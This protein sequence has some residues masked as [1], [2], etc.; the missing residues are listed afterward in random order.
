MSARERERLKLFERVKREELSLRD[1]AAICS[2]SYRQT[3]RLY[4]RYR[5]EG[6]RNM[7]H[8]SRGRQTELC[9]R[10]LK[11]WFSPLSGNILTL[12]QPWRLRSRRSKVTGWTTRRCAVGC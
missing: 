12:A 11:R 7:V 4:K 2:F 8:R 3:R 10:S 6:D 5:E 9:Q 1:A